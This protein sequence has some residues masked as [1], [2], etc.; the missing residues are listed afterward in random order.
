MNNKAVKTHQSQNGS[1]KSNNLTDR[2]KAAPKGVPFGKAKRDPLFGGSGDAPGPGNYNLPKTK[3]S[4]NGG[5]AFGKE[6]RNFG[7]SLLKLK[8]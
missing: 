3:Q 5:V 2:N 1:E 7:E 4:S 6:K 8:L